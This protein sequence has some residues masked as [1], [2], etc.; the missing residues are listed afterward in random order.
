MHLPR[1]AQ[2]PPIGRFRQQTV[3][4]QR[5][6]LPN[7]VS[8][9]LIETSR[10]ARLW[11][12]GTRATNIVS[13]SPLC[14]VTLIAR[15]FRSD[16]DLKS[17]LVKRFFVF[18]ALRERNADNPAQPHTLF[19]ESV[20]TE[21]WIKAHGVPRSTFFHHKKRFLEGFRA[22]NE[23][24]RPGRPPLQ[25]CPPTCLRVLYCLHASAATNLS[26]NRMRARF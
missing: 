18:D 22:D 23:G 24:N 17:N 26:S 25:V 1:L 3:I 16:Y 8:R 11:H 5:R 20:C 14:A 2:F 15:P 19:G 21:C 7:A 6:R 13:E 9:T 4:G 12:S 10:S